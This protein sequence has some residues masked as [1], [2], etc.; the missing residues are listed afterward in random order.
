MKPTAHQRTA[1]SRTEEIIARAVFNTL[2][3]EPRFT[4]LHNTEIV[5]AMIETLRK[6]VLKEIEQLDDT[7]TTTPLSPGNP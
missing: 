6:K 4:R 3:R 2:N 1:L 7:D 5:R